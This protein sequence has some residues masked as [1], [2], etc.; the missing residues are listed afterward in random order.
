MWQTRGGEAQGSSQLESPNRSPRHLSA[1]RESSPVTMCA[2]QLSARTAAIAS[3][4]GAGRVQRTTP[5]QGQG[6]RARS[7]QPPLPARP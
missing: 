7:S 1:N 5:H 3:P 2:C 4:S 6:K